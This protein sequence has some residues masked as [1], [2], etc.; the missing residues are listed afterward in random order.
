M[1][2]SSPQASSPQASARSASR[3]FNVIS[4]VAIDNALSNRYTVLEVAGL[5]RT[6]LL[7]ELTTALAKLNLN[8]A[9]AHIATFGEKVVDVFYVTDLTGSKITHAGRQ[10]A[11]RRTILDVL[12]RRDAG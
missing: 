2:K 8:I 12:D 5:D 6:G 7:Y 1:A 3:A 4:E 10:A 9:S 11:I